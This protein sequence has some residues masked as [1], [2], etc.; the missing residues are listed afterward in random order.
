MALGLR[1]RQVSHQHDFLPCE[2]SFKRKGESIVGIYLCEW[3]NKPYSLFINQY[4]HTYLENNVKF[5]HP[6]P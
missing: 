4:E 2:V 6:F 3:N 5:N 1:V